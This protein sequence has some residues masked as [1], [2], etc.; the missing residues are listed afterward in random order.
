MDRFY[1]RLAEILEE[2]KVGPDD[3]LANFEQWDSL[4]AL[5]VVAMIDEDY[6]VNVSAEELATTRTAAA[7]EALV[8]AKRSK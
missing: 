8:A 4:T 3:V 7:L 1:V 6:Q 2:D 5:S